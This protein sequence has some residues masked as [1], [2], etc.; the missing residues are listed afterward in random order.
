MRGEV[1]VAFASV[2]AFASM[3]LMIFVHVGQINTSNVPR[4]IS[5]AV[6]NMSG[7]GVALQ[8]AI[9]DTLFGIYTTNASAPLGDGIG[10]RQLYK[11]GLYSH[12]AYVDSK[13][14]TCAN[15]TIGE[16]FR[17]YDAVTS[18]LPANYSLITA[19]ILPSDITFRDSK[20][21]GQSS[22]AAY[23][24]LLLGTICTA[25]ALITGIAKN[26]LTFFVSTIF[27]VAGSILLLIGA[28]IWTVIVNKT[29]SFND[30]LLQLPNTTA[31]I[32]ID[33]SA[34]TG[35]FLT[36]GAFACLIVSVVPYMISC[37]TYRG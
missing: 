4:G 12:C 19:S 13:N 23:W 7:Y 26:N 10:L 24:M 9:P 31:P 37:C 15:Q 18:D 14:G 22:K 1:C 27:A 36:W 33:I 11:F 29:A 16:Q 25:I 28:S 35:L 21:L 6:V 3:L 20:Y 34:G 32:G 17:P 2:L 5:M 30:H 8:A